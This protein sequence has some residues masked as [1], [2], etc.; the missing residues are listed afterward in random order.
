MS[1]RL[2]L[3]PV[4]HLIVAGTF[5]GALCLEPVVAQEPAKR[6]LFVGNSFTF[7]NDVP[8]LVAELSLSRDPPLRLDVHMV[9]RDGMT[10][11]RHW[12]EGDV[13]RR[14]GAERWDVVV[15]QE[16]GSR[17]LSEPARMETYARRLAALA[18]AAGAEVILFQTWARLDQPETEEPR[19]AAYRRI[20][21]AIE[22]TVAPVGVAWSRTRR[23]HPSLRL[24]AEDGIHANPVGARLAASVILDTILALGPRR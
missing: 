13:A 5:A 7:G 20:A 1:S 14:L 9:A 6:V 18:R 12:R 3:G 19:A 16:Q 2:V 4:L 23:Q 8:R 17:P 10:L 11:E 15:L 21:N 22:A 24:H